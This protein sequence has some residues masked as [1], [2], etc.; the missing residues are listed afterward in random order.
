MGI[1]PHCTRGGRVG[2]CL[3]VLFASLIDDPDQERVPTALLERINRLP[4]PEG[5]RLDRATLTLAEPGAAAAVDRVTR[6]TETRCSAPRR[7]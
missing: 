5:H 1:H 7:C 2:H 4:W 3:A 6:V